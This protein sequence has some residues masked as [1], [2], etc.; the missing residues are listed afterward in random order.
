[1]LI[2][3]GAKEAFIRNNVKEMGMEDD[4]LFLG[5]RSDISD[6]LQSMDL[7]IFPSLF[8]GLGIVLIEAQA[9]GLHC[10]ASAQ[11]VPKAAQ[12]TNLLEYVNLQ[13]GAEVWANK[14][15]TYQTYIRRCVTEQIVQCGYDIAQQAEFLQA[16]YIKQMRKL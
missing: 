1:M 16:Y 8:E 13:E 11:K 15:L 10:L 12:I 6:L 5:V 2:G 7:F 4:V 3:A 9:A 14:A